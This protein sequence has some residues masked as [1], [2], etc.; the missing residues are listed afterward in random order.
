MS[1][2]V[3]AEALFRAR[4][5]ARRLRTARPALAAAIMTTLVGGLVW[6]GYASPLLRLTNVTVKGT[7]RLSA[8][9]VLAAARVR[10]GVP[11]VA[12]P[13]GAIRRRV[14]ALPAVA[15]VQVARDWPHEL[16]IEVTER[17]PVAVVSSGGGVGSEAELVDASGVAF[18]A[19]SDPPGGLLALRVPWPAMGAPSAPAAAALRVWA[20]LPAPVRQQIRWVRADSPNAVTFGLDRGATVVWGSPADGPAK[21]SV[22]AA[23]M[24]SPASVYDVSTPSVAVTR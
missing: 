6:V 2:L 23:L 9:Q 15:R 11:L 7:S 1:G 21:L 10:T 18:A 17:A 13:V 22:L 4:R 5:R 16:L 24:A 19:T 3:R 8:A 12:I 20:E 14:A